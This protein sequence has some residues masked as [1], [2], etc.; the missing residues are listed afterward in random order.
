MSPQTGA[1]DADELPESLKAKLRVV[2]PGYKLISIL[3][4]G[5]Q[6]TV[7]KAVDQSN[8]AVVAVKL[9]HGGPFADAAAQQRLQREIIALKAL[10][11]PGIVCFIANG[12]TADGHDYLV[13]N[14]VEGRSL[15]ELWQLPGPPADSPVDPA[16]LLKL[17]IRICQAVGAAHRSGITHRDLSPSNIRIDTAGEPHILDFGLARSAFDPFVFAG[18]PTA[19]ITNQFVG[20]IAYASPE[21]AGGTPDAIDIRTDV[22][23][24]GIILYQILTGGQFPYKVEGSTIEVLNNIIHAQPTPPSKLRADG[25]ARHSPTRAIKSH[26]PEVNQTIEAIVLKALEKDPDRRYQSATEFAQDIENYL[27]GRPTNAHPTTSGRTRSSTT[28][29][30]R[31]LIIAFALLAA[32]VVF[33]WLWGG[34][35]GTRRHL[36]GQSSAPLSQTGNST[37]SL[38]STSPAVRAADDAGSPLVARNAFPPSSARY[39]DLLKLIDPR[40][41]AVGDHRNW[42]FRDGYLV[43]HSSGNQLEFPYA[44]PEEYVYRVTFDAPKSLTGQLMFFV[45]VRHRRINWVVGERD[46]TACG[47][48]L[49]DGKPSSQNMTTRWA[50]SWIVPAARNTVIVEVRKDHTACYLNDAL[51]ADYHTDYHEIGMVDWFKFTWPETA[52][53]MFKMTDIRIVA[54]EV[55]EITG[56][57]RALRAPTP[58]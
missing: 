27:N 22:Y 24:L 42:A 9:I 3:G 58:N 55:M 53:V 45:P 44:L 16:A 54:A 1:S 30:L 50:K 48:D 39:V 47:L 38:H 15:D 31:A 28:R 6:A 40:L 18:Q 41:D 13:M 2:V 43:S 23:A 25:Q 20:K 37:T 51:V 5:G 49:I 21:Q 10:S 26:L 11:H 33:Y 19:S 56:T 14:H 4:R 35:F 7:Y 17:F 12:Q 52:G 36:A 46:N 8:G 34:P 32:G 29:T 57:G